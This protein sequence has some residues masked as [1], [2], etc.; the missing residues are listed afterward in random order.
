MIGYEFWAIEIKLVCWGQ[1]SEWREGTVKHFEYLSRT[2]DWLQTMRLN[3]GKFSKSVGALSYKYLLMELP[4]L[5]LHTPRSLLKPGR[6]RDLTLLI[7]SDRYHL[8]YQAVRLLFSQLSLLFLIKILPYFIFHRLFFPPF[9]S[10][11]LIPQLPLITSPASSITSPAPGYSISITKP[12][13][14]HCNS[15]P[16]LNHHVPYQPTF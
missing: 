12:S 9:Q 5:P 11:D 14:L 8:V 4:V 3:N 7:S 16:T 15:N 13:N 10:R 1:I 6:T 2:L